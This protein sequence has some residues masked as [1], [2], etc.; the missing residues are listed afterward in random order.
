MET[1]ED[2]VPGRGL[3]GGFDELALFDEDEDELD[4]SVLTENGGGDCDCE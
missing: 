4:V 1:N 2:F 3:I